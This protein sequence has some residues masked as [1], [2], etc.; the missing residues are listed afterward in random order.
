M[1]PRLGQGKAFGQD[2]LNGGD[3]FTGNVVRTLG[4]LAGGSFAAPMRR[5]FHRPCF[6]LT[7]GRQV[8][9]VVIVGYK[10]VIP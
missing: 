9:W 8:W 10:S 6:P 2:H 3:G 7:K 1:A 5:L 4:L